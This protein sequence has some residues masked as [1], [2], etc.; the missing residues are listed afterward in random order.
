MADALPAVVL[1]RGSDPVLLGDAVRDTAARLLGDAD[2]GLAL[3]DV[4]PGDDADL[5]G[6]IVHAART[7]PFLTDR[8]VVIGREMGTLKVGDVQ[9]LLDYLADPSPTT[10]LVL[11]GGGGQVPDALVKAVRTAGQVVDADAP[12]ASK[13]RASWLAEHLKGGPVTLDR[14]ATERVIAHIGEDV[15][16]IA[17]LLELLA[18]AHGDGARL[19]VDDIEPYLG[20]AGGV[21][22]WELTDAIDAGDTSLALTKLHRMVEGGARHPLVVLATLHNHYARI[23]RLDGAGVTSGAEAAAVLG[24]KGSTFPAEKALRQARRLGTGPIARAVQLLAGADLDLKG[25]RDLPELVVLEVLVARL[26]RLAPRARPA[27]AGRRRS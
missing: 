10:G 21:A 24:M 1:V 27:P 9:P 20:E 4:A 11:A 12:V 17:A 5:V 13:P 18:A 2:P 23:M 19:G 14:D 3:E 15:A 25:R 8:R 16:R 22:P 7:P 26:S 6:R